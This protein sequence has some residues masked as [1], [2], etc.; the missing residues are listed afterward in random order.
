MTTRR[1]GWVSW[2]FWPANPQVAQVLVIE[3][4]RS[5]YPTPCGSSRDHSLNVGRPRE[6][7]ICGQVG[8]S[9]DGPDRPGHRSELPAAGEGREE[10]V[11]EAAARPPGFKDSGF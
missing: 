1:N 9:R 10:S 6:G 7:R 5:S 3:G 2:G 4:R 8:Q 11:G